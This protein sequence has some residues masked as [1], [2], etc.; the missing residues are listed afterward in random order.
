MYNDCSSIKEPEENRQTPDFN[1][2]RYWI[3]APNK[4]TLDTEE[5]QWY[6]NS[7]GR[8]RQHAEG[9]ISLIQFRNL[10]PSAP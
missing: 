7:T 8:H 6:T 10:Q 9:M 5:T 1:T 2:E 4:L 3:C